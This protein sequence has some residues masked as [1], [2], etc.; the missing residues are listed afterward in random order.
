[1]RWLTLAAAGPVLAVALL[2]GPVLAGLAGTILPAFGYLPAL[3]S[4]DF[5]ISAFVALFAEPGL[6][7]SCQLS[8]LTGLAATLIA[9][10][11][12]AAFLAAWSGTRA[13]N[14]LRHLLSPLLAIPHAA[15]AFGLAFLIAPSGWLVRLVSP[16]AT[17]W[18]VPPD[19]AIPNDAMGLSLVAGLVIKEIPFLF[20]ISLAALPQANP[21][22]AVRVSAGFGYGRMAGFLLTVWQP[23]YRQ[24]RL[25]VLAVL[26]FSTS[27]VDVAAIL[28]PGT[29]APL[30]VRLLGWMNDPDLVMRFKASAGALLQLGLSA[31]ACLLWL[32]LERAGAL[33]LGFW[34]RAGWR[35]ERDRSARWASAVLPLA[36]AA[37]IFG[38]MA[39]LALWS[40]AGLWQFPDAWPQD[41]TARS[42]HRALPRLASPL[43]TTL[44]AGFLSAALALV[45]AV[46]C[47]RR[48]E[49]R[50][51]GRNLAWMIYLPLV[52][53]Q[54]AFLFGLQGLA[55]AS[56]LVPGLGLLVVAHLVFVLPYVFLSLSDPWRAWDKRYLAVAAGLGA[57]PRRA[58]WHIR[59]P[60]M[61]AP[62]LTAVAVGFAV[63]AGLY[64]P[65][66]LVGAGRVTTITTEAVAL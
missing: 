48:E 32:A 2:A 22:D 66:V 43:V 38:G 34:Q 41:V 59:M 54:V 12:V 65:S 64:L 16:W 3:G 33:V 40:L 29:P 58:F 63:S 42:W 24:I 61:L 36:S 53:P 21:A 45:I 31:L 57:S 20:L 7:A 17:G 5:S 23:V 15:A 49:E 44:A 37:A 19:A 13:F 26:V 9:T 30:A 47:L 51:A 52:V 39:V 6:A 4:R 60:M 18:T 56:G 11:A 10:L 62:L 50:P 27:V 8:L 28:G 14:A 1:M 35:L 25:A 46:L 55:V